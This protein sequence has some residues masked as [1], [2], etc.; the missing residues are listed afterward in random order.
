MC[1]VEMDRWTVPTGEV[2]V[3]R[4]SFSSERV[5][6]SQGAQAPRASI[7]WK[8]EAAIYGG[9]PDAWGNILLR[10]RWRGVISTRGVCSDPNLPYFVVDHICQSQPRA[11]AKLTAIYCRFCTSVTATVFVTTVY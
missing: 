10:A 1:D 11:V 7:L 4:Q 2:V 3:W 5:W 9:L 8:V 6:V